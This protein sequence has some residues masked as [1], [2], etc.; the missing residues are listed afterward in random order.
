MSTLRDEVEELKKKME[1]KAFADAKTDAKSW[2]GRT[3][4]DL[5][6]IHKFSY[7]FLAACHWIWLNI[8]RPVTRFF[9]KPVPWLWHGYRV[10]WDKA[11]YTQ[12]QYQNRLFSKTR[13]G[14]YLA[15]TIAFVWYLAVPLTV[16]VFDTG[17]YLAT[18]K[19]AETVYLTNSQEILPESNEHSVQGCHE[20]PCTDHNSVY[21]RIRASNF[22]EV[23]SVLHGKG[24]FFPDYV[25]AAVPVSISK[26]T[27]SSYGVRVKL[28]MRG[29]DLYPDLLEAE[30][31][32]VQGTQEKP[33]NP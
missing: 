18:A 26:C 7:Q 16:M 1:Q 23:W 2:T 6:A 8:L 21:Y 27:I 11:V 14:V 17:L 3:Q 15:A 9:Y 30:C 28:L 22:N 12:D 25:A 29:F 31:T 20:L 33:A 4:H 19:R 32:P 5:T 10:L 24:L 13:A